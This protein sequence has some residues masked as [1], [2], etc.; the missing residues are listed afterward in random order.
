MDNSGYPSIKALVLEYV[1]A[2]SGRADYAELT[3]QVKKHFPTSKWQ[4]TH[5]VWYR[6]QI[7]HGPFRH[8]FSENELAA[9]S[10]TKTAG[11]AK[12]AAPAARVIAPA[13]QPTAI[14]V[15]EE[16]AEAVNRAVIAA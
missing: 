16:M 10:A 3:K 13:P 8:P 14:D 15:T 5:W 11:A 9:I 4:P 1:H 2:R 6:S 12:P 7:L